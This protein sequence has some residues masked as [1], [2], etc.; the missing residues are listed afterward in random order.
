VTIDV[1]RLRI[2]KNINQRN[3]IKKRGELLEI[4]IQLKK[5]NGLLK[6][7]K[8]ENYKIYQHDLHK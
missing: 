7:I 8:R 5:E 2:S 4:K 1:K 6:N 3:N